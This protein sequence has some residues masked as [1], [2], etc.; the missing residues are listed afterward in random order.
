M[1]RAELEAML[2]SS[3]DL[4]LDVATTSL[5]LTHPVQSLWQRYDGSS[6][7]F[8]QPSSESVWRDY[9]SSLQR[10]M[11]SDAVLASFLVPLESSP[12]V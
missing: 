10:T 7:T 4:L 8:V 1:D 12:E 5:A 6:P 11:A 2:P 9:L 3:S